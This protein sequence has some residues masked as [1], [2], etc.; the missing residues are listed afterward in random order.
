MLPPPEPLND[1]VQYI[2]A[3]ESEPEGPFQDIPRA[4]WAAFFSA[5]S[6]FFFLLII[7]FATNAAASFV[8]TIVVLFALMA[9]GL[10]SILAAQAKCGRNKCGAT[11]HTRTGPLGIWAAGAQITLVPIAAVIG[12]IAFIVFAM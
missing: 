9:F 10:P 8:V 6:V 3:H 4:I 11:I 5:W 7:F 1:N 12:L 2:E